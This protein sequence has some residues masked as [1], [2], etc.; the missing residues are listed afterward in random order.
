M[1]PKQSK[2]HSFIGEFSTN[3]KKISGMEIKIAE[4]KAILFQKE[5]ELKSLNEE[6]QKT[7]IERKSILLEK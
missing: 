7:A 6:I 4:Q 5:N 3:K 1:P 2:K